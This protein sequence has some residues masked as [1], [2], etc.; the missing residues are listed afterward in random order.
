MT[1]I[2]LIR[3]CE[4]EGNY[5]RRIQGHTNGRA[6]ARGY[7]QIDALAERFRDVKIDALYSSDL[8]RAMTTAGAIT[9]YHPELTL[10]TNPR[11]R[12]IN[13][14]AW[15]NVPWGNIEREDPH[16]LALFSHDPGSWHVPGAESF[17]EL[18]ER[19]SSALLSIAAQHDG[20]TVAVVS[21]GTAI[22]TLL[23]GLLGIPSDE[24]DRMGH[25]DNTAV[26]LLTAENG[27]LTPEFY[28]DNSHLD[29]SISTF[30][31][32]GWWKEKSGSDR[33]NL[34]IY[35][36]DTESEEE[37]YSA[38][39]A[40]AWQ[41]VHGTLNGFSAEGYWR[42]AQSHAKD[43]P[44]CLVKALRG[45]DFVGLIDLSPNRGKTESAGWISL[46]YIAPEYRGQHY[47]AQLL[48]HAVCLFRDMGRQSLRLHV[49]ETNDR[50][51]AFYE[52]N[53]FSCTGGETGAFG[54]L[55]EMEKTL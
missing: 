25:A 1:K 50:A 54:R 45:D 14:G 18:Y 29:E 47:A 9:R 41:T 23:C 3:H 20:Q 13:L 48:G 15:E 52:H 46:L 43:E 4:A 32:Q 49:A 31:A 2:Y 38:C 21:H 7:K 8:S 12:E 22:R 55:L 34:A 51:I 24:T 35:P 10:V 44:Q 40:D 16:Q 53:G 11:L 36:L 17:E 27:A 37:L 42:S 5:Y 6:T 28:N 30:A 33:N 39:Y 19:I 26:C